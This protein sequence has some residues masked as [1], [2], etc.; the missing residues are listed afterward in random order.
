MK[1]LF[2]NNEVVVINKPAGVLVH[3]DGSGAD[4]TI[5][6]WVR[7]T[8]PEIKDVGEDAIVRTGDVVKKP[9]I[10]HRLDKE[11][12][13]ALIIT[14]TQQ[15]FE[16]IKKQFQ[17][18]VVDKTYQAFVYGNIIEDRGEIDRPIGKSKSN[19][20]MWSAQ[21]GARGTLREAKTTFKVIERSH[22]KEVTFLELYPKTGRT[23]QLRVHMKAIHHPIVA[24]S[25]YAPKGEKLLG[26]DRLALHARTIS[27]VLAGERI[28]VEAP[29]PEDFEKAI[30]QFKTL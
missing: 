26:F 4:N 16:E 23:H 11:T 13:G 2:E 30:A 9:G 8:Y 12:T 3:D 28:S 27:F 20:R 17:E 18:H 24:D 5:V 21:R 7:S 15:A 29:Y 6:D 25:L 14:K 19:F 22:S 10:V 1:I